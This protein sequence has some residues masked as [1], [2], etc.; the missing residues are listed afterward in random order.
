MVAVRVPWANNPAPKPTKNTPS[1]NN[2]AEAK[3]AA[4]MMAAKAGKPNQAPPPD[5]R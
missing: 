5:M 3:G 2:S 1:T 4:K